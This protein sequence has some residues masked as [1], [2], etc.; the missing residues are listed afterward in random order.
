MNRLKLSL[1]YLWWML[2]KSATLRKFVSWACF[3]WNGNR[4]KI[5]GHR[6][7]LTIRTHGSRLKKVII[8]IYGDHNR[9]VIK[10]GV[11]IENTR[12]VMRGSRH[13]LDIGERCYITGDSLWFEDYGCHIS[14]GNDTSIQSV[15][16]A[17]TEPGRRVDIGEDCML[18][19]DIDI[20]TGDS[21]SIIDAATMRRTNY[22]MDVTIGAHAW[23]CTRVQILK[24]VTIGEQSIIGA[25]A[26]V[27]KDIPPNCLAVGVPAHV[28][29]KG[30]TWLR[31]RLYQNG[32][33]TLGSKPTSPW[34][35]YERAYAL[36]EIKCYEDAISNYDK[37]ISLNPNCFKS[38]YVRGRMLANLERFLEAIA[39]YD[40]A[41]SLKPDLCGAWHQ[42]GNAL[43]QLRRYEDAIHSHNRALLIEPDLPEAWFHRGLALVMLDKN[44]QALKSY[45]RALAIRPDYDQAWYG[46]ACCY[47]V[48]GGNVQAL[49]CLRHVI[50]ESSNNYRL[51]AQSDPA[52]EQLRNTEIFQE[53]VHKESHFQEISN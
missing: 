33:D 45:E 5:R 51:K 7:V 11:Q 19:H 1:L 29:K 24:G 15:H 50:V 12:I 46:K 22:A 10:D 28:V 42:R 17:A 31:S 14:I 30:V 41:L 53:L 34:A 26:V 6:N 23:I 3:I 8:E 39:S 13:T 32:K 27:T 38:W 47:A 36:G 9:V 35:W 21:H 49:K 48:Q 16:I 44:R 20:R 52:F 37:A 4:R 2:N 40:R 18:S 43:F 25:G